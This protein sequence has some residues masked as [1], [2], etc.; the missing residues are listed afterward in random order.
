MA[1]WRMSRITSGGSA[2]WVEDKVLTKV[3]RGDRAE[4][5]WGKSDPFS[6]H[7]AK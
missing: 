2:V 5:A 3:G 1:V 7:D 6:E 4:L